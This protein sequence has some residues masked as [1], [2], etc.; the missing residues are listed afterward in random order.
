MSPSRDDREARAEAR[1]IDLRRAAL[2]GEASGQRTGVERTGV[3]RRDGLQAVGVWDRL[4]GE[5][6]SGADATYYDRPVLKEPVWIWAVP[7]Y[8]Y[9]GGAAGA[10]SLLAEVAES[11][12]GDETA[13]L[14]RAARRIG[15]AGGG[16]GT[17]LLV[18]D[19][20]RPERFLNMLR[21]FRP[22]SAMS[23]G[24]WTLAA[25]TPVFAASAV[26]P[27]AGGLPGHLGNLLGKVAGLLGMPLAGYTAVLLTNTAVPVWQASRRSLPWLFI[28]SAMS[29][30]GS[31]LGF[32][33]LN[34]TEAGIVRRFEVAGQ[35]AE[36]VAT[37]AVE[38]DVSKVEQVGLPYKEGV[39]G[40]LWRASKVFTAASL[41]LNLL[42]RHGRAV[43]LVSGACGT[44]GALGVRFATFYAGKA[45]ARDPRATFHGQRAGEG[46]AGATGSAAVSGP[47]GRRATD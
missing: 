47:G 38:R 17:A 42:P 21:V 40:G 32:A 10:A 29:A 12:T 14:V 26:L 20:G 43:R 41:A 35:V 27:H 45:S 19:L 8:F 28:G 11:L 25:A 39:S 9:V 7:A 24:S 4:P 13:D 33:S 46:G 15:A 36:L 16:I 44:A 37:A 23:V 6:F 22:T 1:H 30:A 3:E 2:S 31:L 5:S 18:Y 34:E